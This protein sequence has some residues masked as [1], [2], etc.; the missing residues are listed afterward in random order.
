MKSRSSPKFQHFLNG[1]GL[2]IT[3][4]TATPGSVTDKKYGSLYFCTHKGS[5]MNPTLC[6]SDLLEIEAYIDRPIRVGDVIFFLSPDGG[7]PAVH[8]VASVTPDSVRTKGDNNSR[9]DPWVIQSADV[10]GRVIRA[11]RGK[12]RR[13]I[14]GGTAGRLW[15]RG[16]WGF[17]VLEQGLSFFYHRL[18]RSGLLRRLLP[19]QKRIRIVAINRSDGRSFKLLLGNW[20]IGHYEPGMTYWQIQRPFRLFVDI[21]SLPK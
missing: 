17:K 5:S 4:E 12:T 8:R 19:I 3:K 1:T 18:A 6:A 21:Q 10:I 7:R 11:T 13:L 16:L 2:I 14:Y 9:I 20:L 15:S